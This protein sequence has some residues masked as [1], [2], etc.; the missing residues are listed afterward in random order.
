MFFVLKRTCH[1]GSVDQ[2]GGRYFY[3]LFLILFRNFTF[4]A[5]LAA[6]SQVCDVP[7][8]SYH[9]HLLP[10]DPKENLS[11]TWALGSFIPG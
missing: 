9:S 5:R 6:E 7:D 2:S 11:G 3:D 8:S 4:L 10:A 1:F